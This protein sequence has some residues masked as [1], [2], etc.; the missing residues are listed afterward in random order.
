MGASVRLRLGDHPLLVPGDA[1]ALQQLFTNVI[2]NAAQAG[3]TVI[4]VLAGEKGADAEVRVC[5]N[6]LGIPAEQLAC[7]REPFFS[8]RPE[9]TGLG[10]AVADRIAAAHQA[11]IEIE[12]EVGLGTDVRIR[13]K[14]GPMDPVPE[15]SPLR[16][17]G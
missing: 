13:F 2:V 3:A 16:A 11:V 6:G 17:T 5:D 9:G 10:L 15:K 4:E 1:T 14:V 8:T 12:S 7:V